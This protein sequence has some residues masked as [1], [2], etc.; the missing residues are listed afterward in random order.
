MGNRRI[1]RKR[2]YAVEKKGQSVDLESGAGIKDAIVSATQHRQGQEIITE[3]QLDLGGNDILA[4]DGN[5]KAIGTSG[6]AAHITKLTVAKFGII[7]EIR[8]ICLENPTGGVTDID[9]K[10]DADAQSQGGTAVDTDCID[11]INV[12]GEDKSKEYDDHTTL[13]QDGSSEHFLHICSAAAGS[14]AMTKGKYCIYIHGF[15]VPADA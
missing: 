12:I 4:G 3:I 6:G 1:G 10:T 13:G 15:V 5:H 8:A 9:I 7:T 2:L 11:S 14:T